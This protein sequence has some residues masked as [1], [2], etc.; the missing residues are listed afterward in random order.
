MSDEVWLGIDVGTQSVRCVAVTADG[1]VAGSGA[2][3]L[4]SYRSGDRHE[5]KPESWWEAL[6][7]ASRAALAQADVTVRG[8]ALD[9]TSGTIVLTDR[10]GRPVT[11]GLMYDDARAAG[12]AVTVQE[13][14]EDLWRSLGYRPQASWA[15]PKLLWLYRHAD[16]PEHA[17]L[18][19]QADYLTSLLTGHPTAADSS[20]ALKTGY[21]LENEKWP[22]DVFDA[23][24]VPASMLPDVVRPGTELGV[25]GAAAADATGI[26]AGT[27]VKAGMTDGC[28]ALLGSGALGVGS[29]NAVL[30]TT[31]VLKGVTDTRLRDPLGV[32]YSHRAPDGNWLPGGASSAGAG[33]LS[34]EFPGANLDAM[35][36]K[37]AERGG[38][39]ITYPIVSQGERFPFVAPELRRFTIGEVA[40]DIDYYASLLRGV[41][42]V[43]R[44]CFDYLDLLGAPT[45]G[46]LSVTG[47]GARSSYWNQL[48]ADVLQRSIV[49]PEH[50]DAAM[51][52]AIL[53]RAGTGPLADGAHG[54]SR[55]ATKFEP[56]S[57]QT[58]MHDD[59]YLTLIDELHKR[60][61]LPDSVARHARR[62]RNR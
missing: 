15:L 16:L 10:A 32:V 14:G 21:D 36:S 45:H 27:P 54:F 53:A 26:P 62:R 50:A 52:M 44:L 57:D 40:D 61:W 59:S 19:H 58:T 51:G 38:T 9:A 47:G 13:A 55:R 12:E 5:Q 37:A 11:P 18:Q 33:V 1:R 46:T 49:V 6:A 31:L 56:R 20:H 60:G 39:A 30:G 24:G 41:A 34:A 48:R 29:W 3:P 4:T 42:Y 2:H 7:T 23:I 28:A 25:V 22:V 35:N 17:V 43:E 8:V